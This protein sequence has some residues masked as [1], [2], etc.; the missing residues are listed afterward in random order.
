[1]QLLQR[2]LF[3]LSTLTVLASGFGYDPLT[4]LFAG[5]TPVLLPGVCVAAFLFVHM[6]QQQALAQAVERAKSDR[7]TGRDVSA[8][9]EEMRHTVTQLTVVVDTIQQ[10]L[11]ES[12]VLLPARLLLLQ[13]RYEEAVKTL[14][15]NVEQLPASREARWL[16][17]EAL[18]G[19][20]HFSEALPHLQTGLMR[21]D[22]Q[23]LA[24]L[25]HCEQALGHYAEAEQ[26]VL[27]LIEARGETRQDDLVTLGTIQSAL[28]PERAAETLA[29]AL[30][31][32]PLN[33]AARYQLIDLKVR[34]EAYED[35]IALATEGLE[36]NPTD[37]GCF[38]SRAEA[39]LR[40]GREVDE[41]D[42]L[43]DL[44]LAQAK[45]RKDYNIYR[46]RGALHQRQA[47]CAEHAADKRRLLQQALE[48]YDE[49]LTNVPN[50]F[51]AH[52]L[53]AKSR[54]LLQ[55]RRFTDAV[56]TAQ[57]AVE[58]HQGHVS[59][60]LALALAQLA[61][62]Q[63]RPAIHTAEKGMQWAG[64]GGRIWLTAIT[65]FA[66]ACADTEVT[67]LRTKCLSL[68]N[69]LDGDTRDFTLNETWETVR[70]VLREAANRV[71]ATSGAL[72]RDTIALLET[73]ITPA[74]YRQTWGAS[75]RAA[76]S[77]STV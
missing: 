5:V 26:C 12:N 57:R 66:G 41:K 1:M 68:A 77:D 50:K 3:V 30:E 29:H 44:M 6:A 17:G 60:H 69:E 38:V 21:A 24:L 11:D 25:S 74:E 49:G 55:L 71:S 15:Q 39:R 46:L 14:Q 18:V 62:Q 56:K 36:R 33:S 37:I 59:N 67:T 19:I 72:V 64:W 75:N 35:A 4:A 43:H 53:A 23:R 31:L 40:R 22:A 61:A 20:K 47:G 8:Q 32:N 13:R 45:N 10:T 70:D 7:E 54:V 63:W 76:Q 52:L 48:A 51:Q 65:I 73:S 27:R 42:I 16:L 34:T 58:R 9:L 2:I 28:S